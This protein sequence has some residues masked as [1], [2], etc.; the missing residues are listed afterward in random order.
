MEHAPLWRRGPGLGGGKKLL[1]FFASQLDVTRR[2]T[3]EQ[4][5]R[6]AK[7]PYQVVGGV[8]YYER[9]EVK[10]VLA[11]LNL[12][13][14]PKDDVSFGRVVNVP[15]RGIGK[16]SLEHLASRAEAL[17]LPLLAMARR[18]RSLS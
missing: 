2:R 9:Q 10:D 15:P 11:Y 17:G 3:S 7:I 18:S 14:N 8:S 12:L 5:F 13:A 1:Y 6:Q 4:A 16:T